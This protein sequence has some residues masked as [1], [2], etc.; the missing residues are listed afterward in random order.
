M[1]KDKIENPIMLAEEY[2]KILNER[3]QII[4]DYI[5]A[6]SK[7]RIHINDF[8]EDLADELI[9]FCDNEV[10]DFKTYV[11]NVYEFLE[12]NSSEL[13]KHERFASSLTIHTSIL[14]SYIAIHAAIFLTNYVRKNKRS[15]N[16]TRTQNKLDSKY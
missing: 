3:K 12:K 4:D 5:L 16:L 2:N 8:D 1:E 10:A 7:G 9:S 11:D 14:I 13:D 15:I 6:K